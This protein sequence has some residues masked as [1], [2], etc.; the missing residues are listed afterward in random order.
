M[1]D[2]KAIFD[3]AKLKDRIETSYYDDVTGRH[4]FTRKKVASLLGLSDLGFRKKLNNEI[5]FKQWE[6][7]N[8]CIILNIPF[9]E[10]HTYF[11]IPRVT[12]K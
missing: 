11:F 10:I 1:I 5:G 2:K 4:R 9:E 6:I 3:Y 12:Q 7:F 8:L